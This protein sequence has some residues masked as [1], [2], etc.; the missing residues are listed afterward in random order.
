[1]LVEPAG[2]ALQI[3]VIELAYELQ[4]RTERAKLAMRFRQGALQD[5]LKIEPRGC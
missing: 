5:S 3:V 1:V 4:D 2:Q